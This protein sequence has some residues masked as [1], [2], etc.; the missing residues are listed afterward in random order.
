MMRARLQHNVLFGTMTSHYITRHDNVS[1]YHT[2]MPTN[3]I[4]LLLYHKGL[5]AACIRL[6]T[7]V[8]IRYSTR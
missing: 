8:A 2:M 7:G 3:N 1:L 5:L 6:L 4:G